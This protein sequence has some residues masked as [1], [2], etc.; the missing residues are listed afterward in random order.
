MRDSHGIWY[1]IND[2]RRAAER[3]N[4]RWMIGAILDLLQPDEMLGIIMR[5][6]DI[7]MGEI[8]L[9]DTTRLLSWS[10]SRYQGT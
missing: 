10:E 5:S 4:T 9:L 7:P 2:C 6:A 8:S 3:E 1:L